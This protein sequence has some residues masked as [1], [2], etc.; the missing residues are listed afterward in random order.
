M[1]LEVNV[2]GE[3]SFRSHDCGISYLLHIHLSLRLLKTLNHPVVLQE[4]RVFSD[5]VGSPLLPSGVLPIVHQHS[6]PT[7]A[8]TII[9]GPG[10][11]NIPIP[12]VDL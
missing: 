5:T 1:R 9:Y 11:S 8:R 2:V 12:P 6:S 4:S 3:F 10:T 7:A